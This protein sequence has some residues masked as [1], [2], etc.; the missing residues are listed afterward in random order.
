M[1]LPLAAHVREDPACPHRLPTRFSYDIATMTHRTSCPRW[2]TPDADVYA[3]TAG[4]Y[5]ASYST[6]AQGG[7]PPGKV[8]RACKLERV[9]AN[10]R[11]DEPVP[12]TAT[13]SLPKSTVHQCG[14]F[15]EL[16]FS[17]E[18]DVSL[19]VETRHDATWQAPACILG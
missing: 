1:D 18:I 13:P 4:D 14:D 9:R 5:A 10:Q 17:S 16:T 7:A 6:G 15:L 11:A 8:A 12:P 19:S 3:E 2:G